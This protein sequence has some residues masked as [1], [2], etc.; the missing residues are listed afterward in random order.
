MTQGQTPPN[1]Q[2]KQSFINEVVKTFYENPQSKSSE[3]LLI[4]LKTKYAADPVNLSYINQLTP[5]NKDDKYGI[6]TLSLKDTP[7][8]VEFRLKKPNA[9]GGP[10]TENYLDRIDLRM[11]AALKFIDDKVAPSQQEALKS[12]IQK[13]SDYMKEKIRQ[14]CYLSPEKL[15]GLKDN[16]AEALKYFQQQHN[17]AK[18]YLS[19]FN[20]LLAINI[21][22]DANMRKTKKQ[23]Y[24][25]E[26]QLMSDTKRPQ[27]ITAR[28]ITIEDKTY[29]EVTDTKPVTPE[30]TVS[31]SKKD[32]PGVANWL[33]NTTTIYNE[34]FE[35]LNRNQLFRSASIVPHEIVMVDPLSRE[36]A[37][38][39]AR[40]N[41][42]EHIIPALALDLLA[43]NPSQ[44]DPLVVNFEMLTVLS[45]INQL[46][47]NLLDPDLAQ[48]NAIKYAFEHNQGR[49]FQ[50]EINGEM[51]QVQFNAIFHNHGVNL[52]RKFSS[53]AELANQKAYNDV[54]DRSIAIIKEQLSSTKLS[55]QIS[56]FVS[57]VLNIVEPT[58]T[59]I[60]KEKL[61]FLNTSL[62]DHKGLYA[63]MEK[64]SANFTEQ[65]HKRLLALN[66]KHLSKNP[67]TQSESD[68]FKKLSE[69][70][71]DIKNKNGE[72]QKQADD[73]QKELYELHQQI[74]F[75]RQQN[76]LNKAYVFD[77][78]LPL[79]EAST[80]KNQQA[81]TAHIRALYEYN[82]LIVSGVDSLISMDDDKNARNYE[83][84]FYI[85]RLNTFCDSNFHITCK[86]G[87]DRTNSAIEKIKAKTLLS[88]HNEKLIKSESEDPLIKREENKLFIQGYQQ[89]PGNDICGDNM[90]PG[91]QQVDP[92]DFSPDAY[93]ALAATKKVSSLQKG[94]DKLKPVSPAK[95]KKIIEG[96]S[97]SAQPSAAQSLPQ[98]NP[99]L[100]KASRERQNFVGSH[101]KS[102]TNHEKTV[103]SKQEKL[104]T[105]A[106][107]SDNVVALA[108]RVSAENPAKYNTELL[109]F[110]EI[111]ITPENPKAQ[112]F[113]A[114]SDDN[115][116][117]YCVKGAPSDSQL[118]EICA[119]AVRY[120]KNGDVI[121]LSKSGDLQGKIH[122]LLKREIAN[123][124]RTENLHISLTEPP[125]PQPFAQQA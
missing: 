3:E 121:D 119:F 68:E 65:E 20:D 71:I 16:Q 72:L 69:K 58:L 7:S 39:T 78:L 124:G 81:I 27:R 41:I 104:D 67:L 103:K 46:A 95:Q 91:A 14:D 118:I 109:G 34:Q 102:L 51:R 90:K 61:D 59:D 116:L 86:S 84:Q 45:P 42:K 97:M 53:A 96:L 47:D 92:N 77:N 98:D 87:K 75:S 112:P 17:I 80:D 21:N 122:E 114:K 31:S 11:Q 55:P 88:L 2:T 43:K 25:I 110:K 35:E 73:F 62:T 33:K 12:Y 111:K 74:A 100:T 63:Q 125:R 56:A 36:I 49:T 48:Y 105:V 66:E 29:Y 19:T 117:D 54:L 4:S 24:S 1:N 57:E 15:L 32:E 28:P 83:V 89:G 8:N 120:A 18:T 50:I 60:Q 70:F 106:S 6:F 123:A 107:V 64:N 115:K 22:L 37:F 10:K 101:R 94:L 93:A 108:R 99:P 26:R 85:E 44:K 40:R 30:R 76:I 13:L 82:K 23:L 52:L 79:I 9:Y 38:D 5:V 113:Y